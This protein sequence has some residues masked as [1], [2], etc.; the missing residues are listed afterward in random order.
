[1]EK[2]RTAALK[3]G[4]HLAPGGGSPVLQLMPALNIEKPVLDEGLDKLISTISSV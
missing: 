3:N 2:A 1:V 4:L